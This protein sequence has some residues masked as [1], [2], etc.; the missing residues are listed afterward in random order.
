MKLIF[1]I[2]NFSGQPT[3]TGVP[4]V[5]LE[6]L[7][8][9]VERKRCEITTICSLPEE[10]FALRNFRRFF[11]YDLPF[12]GKNV[13]RFTLPPEPPA[14]GKS[15]LRRWEEYLEERFPDSGALRFL[16]G[17]ARKIKWAIKPPPVL[18]QRDRSALLE[19][20]I[21]RADVYFSP[22]HAFVPE[23]DVNPSIR[24]MLIVHDVIPVVFPEMYKS[25]YY[26]TLI[27]FWKTLTPD[28]SV[29]SVSESTKRDLLHHFP[30]TTPEQIT[31]VP[32][33][34]DARFVPSGD[35]GRIA[36][37]VEKYGIPRQAPYVLTLATVEPRK[38]FDHLLR[39]FGRLIEREGERFPDLRLVLTGARRQ[40]VGA[41]HKAVRNL[42]KS[43]RNRITF[44]GYVDDADLPLLYQ[45][46]VCF[47]YM[48]LYE[49][50]G[51]P[52]L[53]AMRSGTPVIAS[54][55]SSL[56]EVVGDAGILLDAR[57]E[58]GLVDALSRV[59][60]DGDLRNDMIAKGRKQAKKFDWD[61][62]VD[63]ICEKIEAK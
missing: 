29:F 46:A 23:I 16:A 45:G 22:F 3:I 55:N 56:P 44:T 18:E 5:V 2:A 61:R 30:N 6:I 38:N 8:R 34:T 27:D 35:R 63:L 37:T 19:N 20:L 54:N 52:P 28:V 15:T 59:L 26:D 57:D 41:V 53:E 24:K 48:S 25:P 10:E 14:P 31:V 11:P 43:C 51:L 49:G 36:R 4:R 13:E 58:P 12:R 47:C 42:P 40:S 39:G 7:L 62:C 60:G 50:F 32:L 17:T 9:I 21:R 1:D 33:G